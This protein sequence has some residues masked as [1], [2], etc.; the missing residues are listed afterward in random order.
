MIKPSR[1]SGPAQDY[2]LP[3][4]DTCFFNVELPAYSS[5]ALM[6]E[7]LTTVIG[8]DWGMSGDD[9]LAMGAGAPAVPPAPPLAR[10]VS[11]P[12][13]A[14]SRLSSRAARRSALDSGRR[15]HRMQSTNQNQHPRRRLVNSEALPAAP[16]QVNEAPTP[17]NEEEPAPVVNEASAVAADARPPRLMFDEDLFEALL[18][19]SDLNSV[20]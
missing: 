7:R 6:R 9:E 12:H 10:T 13:P 5:E 11:T 15:R 1:V 17:V 8:L 18:V 16:A 14:Q 4:A 19:N 2:A 3:H 20:D